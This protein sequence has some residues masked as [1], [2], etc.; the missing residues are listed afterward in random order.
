MTLMKS[1]QKQLGPT[2][3]ELIE[4]A[5]SVGKAMRVLTGEDW[6]E[7]LGELAESLERPLSEV[8]IPAWGS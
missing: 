4:S 2:L 7:K 1:I 3:Q 5:D 8:D 6:K